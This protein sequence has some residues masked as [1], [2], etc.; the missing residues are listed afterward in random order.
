[1]D[2]IVVGVG[3]GVATVGDPLGVAVTVAVGVP[4]IPIPLSSSL[5]DGFV[6]S[7]LVIVTNWTNEFAVVGAKLTATVALAPGTKLKLP[8]PDRTLNGGFTPAALTLPVRVAP[9][10]FVTLKTAI[11][12]VPTLTLPKLTVAGLSDIAGK[13]TGVGVGVGVGVGAAIA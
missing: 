8:E 3:V 4:P 13:G 10:E 6:G 12:T 1:G 2:A 7:S 11:A 5:T 9:P